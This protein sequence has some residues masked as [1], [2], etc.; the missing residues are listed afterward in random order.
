MRGSLL[1]SIWS[2]VS[3]CLICISLV[4]RLLVRSSSCIRRWLL[5][6]ISRCSMLRRCI[7][8]V[9]CCCWTTIFLLSRFG[10]MF[11]CFLLMNFLNWLILLMMCFLND[12]CVLLR[13]WI[14]LICSRGWS[15]F[16]LSRG[17]LVLWGRTILI[18]SGGIFL[19][20]RWFSTMFYSFMYYFYSR[21]MVY[22]LDYLG[23]RC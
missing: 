14:M 1:L 5:V 18:C 21:L 22:I 13:L 4:S 11:Y 6:L 12:L 3:T 9:S 20:L 15:V 8:L 10:T 19:L 2:I 17:V 7:M 16:L 23:N